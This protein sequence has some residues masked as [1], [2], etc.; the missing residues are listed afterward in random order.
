MFNTNENNQSINKNINDINSKNTKNK[1][2]EKKSC[3]I[4]YK[5]KNWK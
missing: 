3:R 1:I 5:C 2:N 4:K